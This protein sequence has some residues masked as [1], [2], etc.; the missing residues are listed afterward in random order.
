MGP[1][2]TVPLNGRLPEWFKQRL[3]GAA[4]MEAM[5]AVLKGFSLH[6]VCQSALCPNIGRCFAQKTATFLIL[7][8]VCTRHCTFCAVT[9]GAPALVDRAEPEHVTAAA[10]DLGLNYAVITSVTRDD[11]PDGGASQFAVVIESL[12]RENI[13]AE[14]LVPDFRGSEQALSIVVAAAP[15][16]LNHNIETVPRLY[17]AVRPEADYTRSLQLLSRA[18]ALRPATVTKS[19]LMLGMGETPEEISAVLSDL[20][21]SGCDL[22][23][24]GQYLQPSAEHHA[25]NRYVPPEEFTAYGQAALNMGFAGVAA[26]PWVRSSYEAAGLYR[27]IKPPA[28]RGGRF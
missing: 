27:R 12:H 20:R 1:D 4:P 18:K 22:V 6:T 15:E 9:K 5:R 11:L 10:A 16:V 24:L 26:A 25:V 28:D 2:P 23:T 21:A 8:D 3:P 14:V 7:G 17:G 13:A 19:G